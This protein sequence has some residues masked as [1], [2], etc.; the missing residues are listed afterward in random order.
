M[1]KIR[2]GILSKTTGKVGGVVGA[3]WKGI[4]Y[5]REHI[6]PANPQSEAQNTQREKMRQMVQLAKPLIG[7]VFHQYVDP[8]IRKMSGFNWFIKKN[9]HAAIK[10]NAPHEIILTEGILSP[11]PIEDLYEGSSTSVDVIVGVRRGGNDLP[12]DTVMCAVYS[13]DTKSWYFADNELPVNDEDSLEFNVTTRVNDTSGNLRGF[14]W[15]IRRNG[16]QI[17]AVST[18]KGN[19]YFKD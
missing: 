19:I 18:S 2:S 17:E 4:N 13:S 12:S 16:N 10:D 11:C 15:R 6:T 14:A 3:S 8:L 5:I 1:A 7:V 9:I